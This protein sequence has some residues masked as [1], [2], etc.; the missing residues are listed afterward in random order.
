MADSVETDNISEIPST[1]LESV[2]S[3]S[4]ANTTETN[5]VA[6]FATKTTSS[7]SKTKEDIVKIPKTMPIGST[8]SV[9]P[10]MTENDG[11]DLYI[12]DTRSSLHAISSQY[13]GMSSDSDNEDN[14]S[15]VNIIPDTKD[16]R[17]QNEIL[18][19][20]DN[21][22]DSESDSSSSESDSDS[23]DSKSGKNDSAESDDENHSSSQQDK[24]RRNFKQKGEFDDL[25][26]IEN[27]QISVPEVL[28]DPLGEVAWTVEQMVVVR[29]KPGK[30]TLNLDT[31]LFINK[32]Q[33]ALGH[34]FDVFGQVSE[35]HYCVRFNS[36][37]HIKESEIKVGMTVYYCPNSE[38]TSL[39][40]LSE[41]TKMKAS[42]DIGEDEP[43]EFSDDEQ[44]QA[45][46]ASIKY[47]KGL[48]KSKSAP[49]EVPNK[50]RRGGQMNRQPNHQWNNNRDFQLNAQLMNS[51]P[52][53]RS[54]HP[55]S[56]RRH[57]ISWHQYNPNQIFP[58]Y[59]PY[60]FIPP[61]QT[62]NESMN[63]QAHG[64]MMNVGFPYMQW[65]P[66]YHTPQINTACPEN[67]SLPSLM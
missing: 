34:I 60:G 43:P 67:F 14:E 40:F 7:E 28:C 9:Q 13:N 47:K 20:S 42:D 11:K 19:T 62:H 51:S 6:S 41:L 45:Y 30:P 58:Q 44:E 24:S 61:M 48:D 33:R 66:Y 21:S 64:D 65:N 16:Y 23:E 36:S 26:P 63:S 54:H 29:P 25:P 37:D 38:Y 5:D 17:T 15:E 35:P 10:S 50:R 56:N 31:V 18:L 12:I 53:Y 49:S 8:V 2:V 1:T 27:L 46:L 39:V 4:Q 52:F 32:G 57:Q 55:W 3:K 59:P 22:S